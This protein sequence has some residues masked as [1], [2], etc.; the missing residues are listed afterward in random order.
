MSHNPSNDSL[1][2]SHH[3]E[4]LI[5]LSQ[6]DLENQFPPTDSESQNTNDFLSKKD[7]ERWYHGRNLLNRQNILALVVLVLLA[8]VSILILSPSFIPTLFNTT[9]EKFSH[10]RT[11]TPINNSSQ[12][13]EKAIQHAHHLKPNQNMELEIIQYSSQETK[14]HIDGNSSSWEFLQNSNQEFFLV[15]TTFSLDKWEHF[16]N[17]V[18]YNPQLNRILIGATNNASL[19]Q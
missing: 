6:L 16:I 1:L 5:D 8:I 10:I 12:Q 7:R 4:D 3:D 19:Q 13:T 17:F 11:I 18:D 9:K 2:L 14:P 15:N